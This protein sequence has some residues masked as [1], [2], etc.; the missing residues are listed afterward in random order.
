MILVKIKEI[1]ILFFLLLNFIG[2]K[3]SP[4][5]QYS[6]NTS[7][8]QCVRSA[9]YDWVTL[10]ISSNSTK[11]S[12]ESIQALYN[13]NNAGLKVD[14]LIFACRGISPEQQA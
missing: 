14:I 4:Y 5:I 1:L 2:C 9:G 8:Y 7:Y 13:A 6:R 10:L 12:S 3:I 11:V